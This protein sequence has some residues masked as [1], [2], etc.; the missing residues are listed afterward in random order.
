MLT[1]KEFDSIF[2]DHEDGLVVK[3][4]NDVVIIS[5]KNGGA[6]PYWKG[7]GCSIYQQRPIDCRL[8]PYM[9]THIIQRKNKV[10]ITFH[11]LND[12]PRRDVLMSEAEG[13]E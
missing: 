9:I 11:N 5:P 2:K 4:S 3:R 8:H 13:S 7:E 10:K 1:E 6:C 12:C